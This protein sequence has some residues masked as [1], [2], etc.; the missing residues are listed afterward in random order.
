MQLLRLIGGCDDCGFH[1]VFYVDLCR[2]RVTVLILEDI[3]VKLV[4]SLCFHRAEV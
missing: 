1:Y 4:I 2:I 3:Y